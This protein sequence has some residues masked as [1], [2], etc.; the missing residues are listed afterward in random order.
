METNEKAKKKKIA[1]RMVLII[2]RVSRCSVC[3]KTHNQ[4]V[5]PPHI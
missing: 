1:H 5:V 2:D 4:I 3:M